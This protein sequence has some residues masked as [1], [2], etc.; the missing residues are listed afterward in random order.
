M[1]P[2]LHLKWERWKYNK[3]FE[4]WVSTF[5]NVRNHSKAPIAPV[6]GQNGYCWYKV[7]GSKTQYV[8]AH[9]LVMLTWR[10]TPEAETLTV[11]H[12][13]HNKRDNSLYNLEWVTFE[14]NQ[15]RAKED[16]LDEYVIIHGHKKE[17]KKPHLL[18]TIVNLTK[19][20]NGQQFIVHKDS[21]EDMIK[22]EAAYLGKI[23]GF[24]RDRF[25]EILE[26]F[27][28]GKIPRNTTKTWCGITFEAAYENN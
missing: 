28:T 8:L 17:K 2:T 16:F 22:V 14:E 1:L 26:A 15:R 24:S 19:K 23:S 27:W 3:T 5:G 6:V 25:H 9:R 21:M 11:D 12:L 13:N 10:P 18:P 4:V 7:G 20:E